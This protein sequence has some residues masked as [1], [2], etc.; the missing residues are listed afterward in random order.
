MTEKKRTPSDCFKELEPSIEIIDNLVR[1]APLNKDQK[2]GLALM[3]AAHY[4]GLTA[5][6]MG[7]DVRGNAREVCDLIVQTMRHKTVELKIVEEDF[8]P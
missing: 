3:M 2:T 1:T 4:F 8:L 7:K 5:S 6:M